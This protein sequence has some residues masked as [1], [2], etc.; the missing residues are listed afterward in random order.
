MSYPKYTLNYINGDDP[1][2]E[3]S[4]N[5]EAPTGAPGTFD[6]IATE[7]VTA[8]GNNQAVTIK[9]SHTHS[10]STANGMVDIFMSHNSA[11]DSE[12]TINIVVRSR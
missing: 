6:T 10:I 5:A 11:A 12:P 8:L 7:A 1:R 3:I 9:G 4:T 2:A